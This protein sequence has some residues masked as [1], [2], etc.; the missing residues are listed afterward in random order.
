[1][2][3]LEKLTKQYPLTKTTSSLYLEI[4]KTRFEMG[5]LFSENKEYQFEYAKSLKLCDEILE[6]V[7]ESPVKDEC[8]QLKKKILEVLL[9]CQI[10]TYIPI[11]QF[12]KIR[13][14]Y[15]NIKEVTFSI[16]KLNGQSQREFAKKIKEEDKQYLIKKLSELKE[17]IVK[18]PDAKD[19]QK[20][21]TE[22]VLPKLNQGFYLLVGKIKGNKPY[23]KDFQV[24]NLTLL[25]QPK[26]KYQVLDRNHGKPIVNAKVSLKKNEIIVM[27]NI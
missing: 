20:Y 13:I 14:D 8:E 17:W 6:K 10:D 4:A 12:S 26:G 16:L 18:L 21:S 11:Q 23:L 9:N 7:S 3:F 19:H 24:T 22:I 27:I 5:E 15:K 2:A 25:T 1:M